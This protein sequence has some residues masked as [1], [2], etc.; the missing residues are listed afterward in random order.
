M[1]TIDGGKL[2]YDTPEA[3]RKELEKRLVWSGVDVIYDYHGLEMEFVFILLISNVICIIVGWYVC[4][5]LRVIFFVCLD[6]SPFSPTQYS[7][8]QKASFFFYITTINAI[9]GN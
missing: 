5:M 6:S 8:L 3:A 7:P 4:F 9:K 2:I 1:V